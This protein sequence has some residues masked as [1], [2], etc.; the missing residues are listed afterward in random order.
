MEKAKLFEYAVI[1]H[2][3]NKEEKNGKKAHVVLDPSTIMA[4]NESVATMQVIKKIP[5]EYDDRM[6]QLEIAIRPF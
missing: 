6:E 1:Y 2:P 4:T 3:N 5:K